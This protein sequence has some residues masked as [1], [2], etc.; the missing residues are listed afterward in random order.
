MSERDQIAPGKVVTMRYVLTGQDGKILE[1]SGAEGIDY[2]HGAGNIVPGLEKQMNGRAVGDKLKAEVLPA[3]GYGERRG[4]PQPVPRTAFPAD[5]ELQVGMEFMAEGPDGAPMP[6]WIVG[7]TS[8]SVEV[9]GNHPLAGLTLTFDV[10]ILAIRS[11][12]QD[13]LAHGHPHG[14][15]EHHHH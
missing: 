9:D 6:L 4:K 1:E 11:A 3:E 14:P 12:T 7:I 8:D 10:E 5:V 13:E 2:L 15:H